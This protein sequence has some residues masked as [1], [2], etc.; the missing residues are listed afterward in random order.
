MNHFVVWP[1]MLEEWIIHITS[2]CWIDP[3][4]VASSLILQDCLL[5]IL[6]VLQISRLFHGLK[7]W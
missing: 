5:Q 6:L 7:Q 1:R 3:N 2:S 4:E